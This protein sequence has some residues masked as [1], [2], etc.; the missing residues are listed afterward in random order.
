MTIWVAD[1]VLCGDV[2]C[3]GGTDDEAQTALDLHLTVTHGIEV[4]S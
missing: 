1:C 3:E 2:V 4:E